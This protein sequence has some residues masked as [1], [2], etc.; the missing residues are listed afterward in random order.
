ML[1]DDELHLDLFYAYGYAGKS[2]MAVRA[3]RAM[4]GDAPALI[5]RV[6]WIGAARYKI[7][8]IA[9]QITGP[10]AMGEPIGVEVRP[11]QEDSAG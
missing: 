1:S 3:P 2:M 9:R 7:V 11:V 4:T 6:A 8:S 5:G 10:I